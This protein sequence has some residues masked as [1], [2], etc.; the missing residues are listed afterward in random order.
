[1]QDCVLDIRLP[2]LSHTTAAQSAEKIASHAAATPGLDHSEAYTGSS[3]LVLLTLTPPQG[4][5]VDTTNS[6]IHYAADPHVFLVPPSNDAT[7]SGSVSPSFSSHPGATRLPL[8]AESVWRPAARPGTAVKALWV[9]LVTQDDK[10]YSYRTGPHELVVTIRERVSPGPQKNSPVWATIDRASRLFSRA[11]VIRASKSLLIVS[12]VDISCTV[13]PV[14]GSLDKPILSVLVE[15]AT[16]DAS[17]TL[18][19][20]VFNLSSSRRVSRRSSVT[21]VESHPAIEALDSVYEAVPLFSTD[22]PNSD[23]V[24]PITPGRPS[25]GRS[26]ALEDRVDVVRLNPHETFNFVFRLERRLEGNSRKEDLRRTEGTLRPGE[27]VQTGVAVS[28]SCTRSKDAPVPHQSKPK[29]ATGR[30]LGS[31]HKRTVSVTTPVEWVPV[32]LLHGILVSLT[33]PPVLAVGHEAFVNVAI[34]N[35]LDVK[36]RGARLCLQD[37]GESMDTLESMDAGSGDEGGLLA[38]R[39]VIMLG[40]IE[41]GGKTTVQV[42]CVAV[43]TGTVRLGAVRIVCDGESKQGRRIWTADADFAAIAVDVPANKDG[44][45]DMEAIE[46][47]ADRRTR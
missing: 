24:P 30:M 39:T 6:F 3:V 10:S 35:R 4:I 7:A 44:T 40:S 27:A 11:S 47:V 21:L 8:L 16:P 12:P 31:D 46:S 22:P 18:L 28:W 9:L 25:K 20:P 2:V 43:R 32:A 41:N 15:N 17:V 5:T 34:V 29:R 42:P 19:P 13:S 1:M 33:G 23:K 36:L 45:V 38:L 14:S 37:G 26:I